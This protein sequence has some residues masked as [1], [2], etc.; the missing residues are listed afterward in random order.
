MRSVV[1]VLCVASAAIGCR[2][3]RTY[4]PESSNLADATVNTPEGMKNVKLFAALKSDGDGK[5]CTSTSSCKT[6]TSEVG[7]TF[8]NGRA[9]F[10]LE[11]DAS[12][13]F[14]LEA[15]I[16]ETKVMLSDVMTLTE[17]CS[18]AVQ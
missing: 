10:K 16:T 5:I 3:K 7:I 9:H 6:D 12:Y 11:K 15:V 1:I 4:K 17:S 18:T 8:T 2:T 14:R 13:L